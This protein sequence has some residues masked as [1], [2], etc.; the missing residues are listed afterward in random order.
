MDVY[1]AL[2]QLERM[3]DNSADMMCDED[4]EVCCNAFEVLYQF[5][6]KYEPRVELPL[7]FTCTCGAHLY[8][9]DE[10]AGMSRFKCPDCEAE[11]LIGPQ[12]V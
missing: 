11:W 8:R 3:Y 9:H 12:E 7:D 2:D 4:L 5:I 1:K 6:Q 10:Y